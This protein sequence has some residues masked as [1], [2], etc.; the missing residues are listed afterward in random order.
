[1]LHQIFSAALI[2]F[3]IYFYT[4]E[5]LDFP[6][7]TARIVCLYNMGCAEIGKS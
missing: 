4:H 6:F 5:R 1:M 7:G 3:D 2:F